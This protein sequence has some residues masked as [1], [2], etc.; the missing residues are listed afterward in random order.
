LLSKRKRQKERERWKV[1]VKMTKFRQKGT[2]GVNMNKSTLNIGMIN[3][4]ETSGE[5]KWYGKK[6]PL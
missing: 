5:E 3:K 2:N 6:I 4:K 1:K